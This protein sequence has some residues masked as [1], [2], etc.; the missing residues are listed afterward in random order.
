HVWDRLRKELL[1]NVSLKLEETGSRSA[2]LLKGRGALQ[3]SILIET[4]RREGYEF[5]VSKPEVIFRYID[6]REC[7]PI[8][9]AIIDVA[10][11]YAGVVIEMFG[12][13]KGELKNM[14]PG[15]G[16]Y[17]RLEFHIPSRSLLGINN[18]FLTATHGNGILNHTFYGYEPYKGDIN[19]KIKGVMIAL[20]PGIS[21]AYGL[22]NLQERGSLFIG[23]GISVYT[24]MIVGEH[25]RD[26]D[27]VVNVC[28]TKKLTNMRAAGSDDAVRL[29]PPRQ[30]TLEQALEYIEDDE[31]L[32]ITPQHIRMRKKILDIHAR[33]QAEKLKN[34]WNRLDAA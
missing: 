25:C 4:M 26:N 33:K 29:T 16:G 10:N 15:T 20:E 34:G 21:V 18:E 19:R 8:E 3:L 7:E 28:K 31:L 27:L 22:F 24:G 6:G 1:S 9:L 14:T 12:Q 23:A 30:F 11:Q 17:T 2:F 32:E 13:R 5:Q